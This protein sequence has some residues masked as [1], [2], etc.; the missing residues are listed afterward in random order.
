MSDAFVGIIGH[1]EERVV[2]SD[3]VGDARS[4]VVDLPSLAMLGRSL[5]SVRGWFDAEWAIACRTADIVA[6]V[7][8][9][10]IS[11]TA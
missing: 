1:T 4:V 10:G 9:A 6:L 7:C 5:V 2:S 8:E 11:G 3:I